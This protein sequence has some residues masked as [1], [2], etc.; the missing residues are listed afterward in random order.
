MIRQRSERSEGT[1]LDFLALAVQIDEHELGTRIT[2]AHHTPGNVDFTTESALSSATLSCTAFIFL[3]EFWDVHVDR[4][5]VWVDVDL[6]RDRVRQRERGMISCSVMEEIERS[7]EKQ[8]LEEQNKTY[9]READI[10]RKRYK[11]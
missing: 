4:P 3:A 10:Q 5:F 6:R 1:H 2:H 7:T 9:N 11:L 8:R